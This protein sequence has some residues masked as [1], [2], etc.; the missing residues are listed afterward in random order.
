MGG[1]AG[2]LLGVW[3]ALLRHYR[4]LARHRLHGGDPRPPRPIL[5]SLA[6]T[7][8]LLG[9][10]ALSISRLADPVAPSGPYLEPE[11]D[12]AAVESVILLLGDAGDARW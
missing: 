6:V 3:T 1:A 4:R 12:P 9:P 8:L 7:A 10:L 5:L 11:P 2:L